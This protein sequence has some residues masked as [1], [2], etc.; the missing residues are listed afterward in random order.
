M[1]DAPE[2]SAGVDRLL[3]RA[4]EEA[5]RLGHEYVGTEHVLLALASD[6]DGVAVVALR[7][8]GV[9]LSALRHTV[10]G[11]VTRGTSFVPA[12]TTRPVTSRTKKALQLAESE[13]RDMG[14]RH[15]GTEHLLLGL[16]AEAKNIAAQALQSAGV[17]LAAARAE[18]QRILG[19]LPPNG[20]DLTA[21]PGPA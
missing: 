17:G 8:L 9:D 3:S 18:V 2:R 12:A 16:L 19:A 1:P 7:N 13:A 21:G 14:H 20:A 10:D 11:L 4:A 15:L 5:A 6:S